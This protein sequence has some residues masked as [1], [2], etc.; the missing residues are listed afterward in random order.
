MKEARHLCPVLYSHH[1]TFKGI[2]LLTKKVPFSYKNCHAS[3][4]HVSQH[5]ISTC[6][7]EVT[8]R[9]QP[10]LCPTVPGIER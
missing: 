9:A 4:D 6:C 7:L 3:A 10:V 2:L 8:H 5:P 1:L